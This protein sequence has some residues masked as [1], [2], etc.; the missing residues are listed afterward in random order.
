MIK[1]KIG[2]LAAIKKESKDSKEE[3]STKGYNNM[4]T[5]ILH[6]TKINNDIWY[7]IGNYSVEINSMRTY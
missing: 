4:Y 1:L 2:K 7:D 3:V 5:L 6:L